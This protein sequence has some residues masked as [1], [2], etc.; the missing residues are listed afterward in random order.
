MPRRSNDIRLVVSANSL[1]NIINFRAGLLK[2]LERAGFNASIAA[3]PQDPGEERMIR[4]PVLPLK[5]KSDGLNPI[6][7]LRLLAG[8][9]AL[10][11][12]VRPAAFLSWTAKPNIY[13]SLAARMLGIPAFPNVSGLG[14]AF[15]R[16]GWLERLLCILYKTAFQ[17]CPVVFFQNREDLGLF[18]ERGL[19]RHDQARLLPG[20]GI[21]LTRFAFT[22]LRDRVDGDCRFLFVGRL[23]GDKGIRELAEAAARVRRVRPGAQF[24]L[25]GSAEVQNR[26]I[27]PPDELERWISDGRLSH[28][29]SV[30]DVRPYLVD[31]DAVILPSYREGLPR[32]LLEAAAIG[33]PMLASDVPGNRDLV[34]HQSN[35]LLFEVRSASAIAEACLQFMDLTA[36]AKARMGEAARRTVETRFSEKQVVDAYLVAL[37]EALELCQRQSGTSVT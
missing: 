7:D 13:G 24:A 11:R 3:P 32:S 10:L 1:W 27:V 36:A 14:T 33:R 19:V 25:L 26:T 9:F 20:S 6:A 31:A 2:G 29:G 17:K 16:N 5:L 12:R 34:E 22:P 37:N 35:G 21:D 15:L 4:Y 28:L 30:E 23:L 8:F 18:V